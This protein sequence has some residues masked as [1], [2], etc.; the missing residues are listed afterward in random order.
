MEDTF[1][2]SPSTKAKNDSTLR[3]FPK[4]AS[5]AHGLTL[6]TVGT[7]GTKRIA[8]TIGTGRSIDLNI[9]NGVKRLSDWNDRDGPVPMMNKA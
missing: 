7:T 3:E 5:S 1:L 4:R 8:G 9:L 2:G 6:R